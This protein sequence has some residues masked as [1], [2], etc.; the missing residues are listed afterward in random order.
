MFVS[1]R[2]DYC[3]IL[4]SGLPHKSTKSLQMV[5]NAA[6][7][8]L[9]KTR[10]FDHVTPILASFH[11]LPIHVRSDFKVLL[12]TY[13]IVNSYLSDLI[14]PY[15]PYRA[16]C[17]QN[18]GLLCVPRVKK[19]SAGCRAFSY[20]APFLW[21]NLPADIRQSDSLETIKS[22]LKTHLFALTF[23]YSNAYPSIPQA[24][25]LLPSS[26]WRVG[27][28]LSVSVNI[29]TYSPCCPADKKS[30]NKL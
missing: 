28:S 27:L 15:V 11:W 9:T 29:S 26:F 8:I 12:V 24:L 4:L 25:Y 5:Q 2:L 1:S 13:K 23:D 14:K 20:R 19:K 21:N 30:T 3:N 18:I 16:L 6:T 7:R 22:Q 17:S 10:N